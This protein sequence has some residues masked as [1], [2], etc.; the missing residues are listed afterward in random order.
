MT[1]QAKIDVG[2]IGT[3]FVARHFTYELE[4]RPGYRL[5]AVW[6]PRAA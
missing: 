1:R 5:V 6:R 2:V 4:R 3:G